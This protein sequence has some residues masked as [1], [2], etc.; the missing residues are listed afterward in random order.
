MMENPNLEFVYH[1]LAYLSMFLVSWWA[2]RTKSLKFFSENGWSQNNRIQFFLLTIGILVWGVIPIIMSG[3][4]SL[5]ILVFGENLPSS[6]QLSLVFGLAVLAFFIGSSQSGKLDIKSPNF[7]PPPTIFVISS[8]LVFRIL[9]LIS[10]EIWFRGFFLQ[11]LVLV[12]PLPVAIGINLFF[13][14]LI[15]IFSGPK[16]ALGSIGFGAILCMMVIYFGSFWPAIT[17]HLCLSLGYEGSFVVR[18][19]KPERLKSIKM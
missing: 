16:Q 19:S 14:A 2:Y 11:D 3:K 17:I 4:T 18:F 8:F 15:H 5:L 13:Y 6:I 1:G 9:F 7:Q 10:Y 12:F